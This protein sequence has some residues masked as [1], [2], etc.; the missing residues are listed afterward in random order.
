MNKYLNLS[1]GDI[2]YVMSVK[3]I[4]DDRQYVVYYSR[5]I[6]ITS[7]PEIMHYNDSNKLV[8]F[9]FKFLN[10][11]RNLT[12]NVVVPAEEKED[13]IR[14]SDEYLNEFYL[15]YNE[16]TVKKLCQEYTKQTYD[17]VKKEIEKLT[18]IA[19]KI[20]NYL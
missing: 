17:I 16:E 12:T 13:Y 10:H 2:L 18:D 11:P 4:A 8:E 1:K 19:K 6:E 15:S 3:H 20:E 7:V 14:I 5:Q 9:S